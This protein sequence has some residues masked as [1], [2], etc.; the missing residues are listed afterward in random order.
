MEIGRITPHNAVWRAR[1]GWEF[2]RRNQLPKFKAPFWF[3]TEL[4]N[5]LCPDSY[6]PMQ[7]RKGWEKETVREVSKLKNG[8]FVDVGANLG[9]YTVIAARNR[10]T[11]LAIEANPEVARC[12]RETLQANDLGDR[13]R[14]LNV[15]A[16]SKNETLQFEST[17]DYSLGHVSSIPWNLDGRRVLSRSE[18][19][20]MTLDSVIEGKPD[21]MK[22]DIEGSEPEALSGSTAIIRDRTRIIFEAVDKAHYQRCFNLL[23]G[24]RVEYLGGMNYLAS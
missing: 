22:I 3:K 13:V 15:A 11:V 10:N 18:V 8:F 17:K 1:W 5:F 23:K 9:L 14:V 20:G 2:I 4:G 19:Q 6:G 21:L 12:L 7:F 24:Y 16:W